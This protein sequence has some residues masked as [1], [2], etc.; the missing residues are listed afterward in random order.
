MAHIHLIG[1]GG[2]GLSAIA[3]VLLQQNHI[4][5]GSDMQSSAA[6][7]RLER[8]GAT[9]FVGQ[10][11]ENLSSDIDV[12]VV[13]SAVGPENPELREA[14]QRGLRVVKRAEWLGE[15]MT[16]FTGI[17]IAGTHGKT[18]T[19][20][21][22]AF[23]LKEAGLDPT[24]I[25]GGFVS[26]M[27][28]N[29]AAGTGST[30]VIEADEYD[31]MF[32]GLH[33][34]VAVITVVEWDHPDIFPS[35]VELQQA[36]VQFIQRVPDDGVV[37]GCGDAPGV[38]SVLEVAPGTV[39]TYGVEASN[40][41]Q[42]RDLVVNDRGGFDFLAVSTIHQRTARVSLAVPGR[43]NVLNALAA[44]A[45]GYYQDIELSVSAEILGQFRGVERRFQLK[46]MV[47]GITIIDDYA[48]HPTEIRATLA[49]ARARY[50]E[51]SIWAVFQP[52]TFSR[53]W[54]LLDE[55]ATA[56]DDADHV[57]V[58]DIYPA[59]EK[60]EGR[61]HSR[62]LVNRMRH[63]DSCYTGSLAHTVTT[64]VSRLEPPAVVITL[65]A[66]DGYQVGEQLLA[67]LHNKE[68]QTV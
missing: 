57:V 59:R 6:T 17:A 4:V 38:R 41:W 63:S 11:P 64:L 61:I 9:V 48:H 29:A 40:G 39:I 65:G 60:D 23:L 5:S 46:G 24:F 32:L 14:H 7:Q 49:A 33:P 51:E 16:G 68:R 26:Q 13:S 10:H 19:T 30:F 54:S 22:I 20:A 36:F 45:V 43:H 27:N 58:L 28:A 47:K 2:A 34:T 67:E 66:G 52:H 3:T 15:M 8:Q 55:F 35:P 1:I 37:L 31:N 56:F 18:T 62:D 53:T 21:M 42:A 25:I 44:L 12:V 50:P